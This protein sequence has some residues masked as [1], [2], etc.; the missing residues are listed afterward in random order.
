MPTLE[1]LSV[2]E[3]LDLIDRLWDSLPESPSPS[4]VPDWHIELLKK[5]LAEAEA[6][7]GEGITWE[8]FKAK[9]RAKQ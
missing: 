3:R 8:E 9:M 4:E 2:K 1:K 5:R 7:P 6:N